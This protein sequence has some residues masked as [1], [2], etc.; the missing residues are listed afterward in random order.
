MTRD[1]HALAL[2]A[3]AATL[4][5]SAGQFLNFTTPGQYSWTAPAA[6]NSQFVLTVVGAAGGRSGVWCAGSPG[7]SGAL[8]QGRTTIPAG[9][10]LTLIVGLGGKMS[11]PTGSQS[12]GGGGAGTGT[13]KCGGSGGGFSGVFGTGLTPPYIVSGGGGGAGGGLCWR[14]AAAGPPGGPGYRAGDCE[15]AIPYSAGLENGTSVSCARTTAQFSTHDAG[16][17]GGL[18]SGGVNS[19]GTTTSAYLVGANGASFGSGGGGGYYGGGAGTGGS[20]AGGPGGGGSSY[21]NVANVTLMNA[22]VVECMAK[23]DMLPP[24]VVA[25]C[26]LTSAGCPGVSNMTLLPS[27]AHRSGDGY[28]G[29]EV[30]GGS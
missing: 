3:A 28:I 5:T 21:I 11:G 24:I 14:G 6:V 9:T 20:G 26:N 8:V 17:G 1:R 15:C 22:G 4:A 18:T 10:T 27:T 16:G 19:L 25:A 2:L 12:Q 29:I 30:S 7:G 13:S 23:A